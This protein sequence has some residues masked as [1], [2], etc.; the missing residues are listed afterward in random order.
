MTRFA[1]WIVLYAT[2]AP[3]CSAQKAAERNTDVSTVRI[4]SVDKKPTKI[5]KPTYPESAKLAG[6]RGPVV[7][8]IIIGKSG[9]V[10]MAQAISGP[11][12]LW[13]AAI[14]AVKQW[15]WEPF[16]LNEK[17]I[18]VRTKVTVNFVLD[19]PRSTKSQVDS[20]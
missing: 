6:I 8:D 1:I 9:E 4:V 18:R 10:E 13:S 2:L 20:H 7:L 19:T 5:V 16:L 3:F 15:K 11:K 17:P 14:E 12:K